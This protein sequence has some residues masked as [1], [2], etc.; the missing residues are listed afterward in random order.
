MLTEILETNKRRLM[1]ANRYL[2]P[3]LDRMIQLFR[4]LEESAH[5]EFLESVKHSA[6]TKGEYL[7]QEGKPCRHLWLLESGHLR[8]FR[9]KGSDEPTMY[10]YFPGEPVMIPL[11]LRQRLRM[12]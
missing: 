10:F 3:S 9:R 7:I 6:Y 4:H 5:P 11:R 2:G 1:A 8:V 12:S